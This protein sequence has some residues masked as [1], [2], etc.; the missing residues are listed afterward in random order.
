VT[1]VHTLAPTNTNTTHSPSM[2]AYL[3]HNIYYTWHHSQAT[4]TNRE[5]WPGTYFVQARSLT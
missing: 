4:P 1:T 3:T 5:K 2:L